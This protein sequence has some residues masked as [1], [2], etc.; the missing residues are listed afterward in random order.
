MTTHSLIYK[1][2]SAEDRVKMQTE[3][4]G[5]IAKAIDASKPRFHEIIGQAAIE[6]CAQVGFWG[7]WV[8]ENSGQYEFLDELRDGIWK[9]VLATPPASEL[10]QYKLHDLIA[11]W[12]ERYPQEWEQVVSA[13]TQAEIKRLAESLK[14]E[15]SLNRDRV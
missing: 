9:S 5:L 11:A 3:L 7:D 2:L 15:Q 12:R 10:S 6:I 8:K 14:F 1:G 4:E 13:D